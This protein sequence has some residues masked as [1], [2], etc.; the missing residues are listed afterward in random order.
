[1]TPESSSEP[2][3]PAE[4]ETAAEG[5]GPSSAARETSKLGAAEASREEREDA[6]TGGDDVVEG[7][8][9]E[10][11]EVGVGGDDEAVDEAVDSSFLDFLY[12]EPSPEKDGADIDEDRW[13]KE[14]EGEGDD[15]V[16]SVPLEEIWSGIVGGMSKVT[17][18]KKEDGDGDYAD[19]L[20]CLDK[21]EDQDG[22]GSERKKKEAAFA[23]FVEFFD[24]PEGRAVLFAAEPCGRRGEVAS[25]EIWGRIVEGMTADESSPAWYAPI[26]TRLGLYSPDDEKPASGDPALETEELSPWLGCFRAWF[27]ARAREAEAEAHESEEGKECDLEDGLQVAS[28]V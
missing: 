4:A 14:L 18:V 12:F 2:R 24:S 7:E 11:G 21:E 27:A 9:Q 13:M 8:M 26:W 16:P 17:M 23:A 6:M 28:P 25:E 15:D 19:F 22:E 10:D 1:M 20:D 3:G 5:G